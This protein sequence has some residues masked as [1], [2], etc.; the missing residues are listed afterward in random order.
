MFNFTTIVQLILKQ[1]KA[2]NRPCFNICTHKQLLV[3]LFL[4][5]VGHSSFAQDVAKFDSSQTKKQSAVMLGYN[6]NRCAGNTDYFR[7]IV[8]K[9][10]SAELS[11]SAINRLNDAARSLRENPCCGLKFMVTGFN[12]KKRMRLQTKRIKAITGYLVHNQAIL[13]TRISREFEETTDHESIF[14]LISIPLAEVK[15]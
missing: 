9:I 7:S 4:L 12:N 6:T 14:D 13:K 8:F 15:R 1:S 11:D 10:G 3:T 2:M 5:F